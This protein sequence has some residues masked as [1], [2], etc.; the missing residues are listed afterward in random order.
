MLRI[1]E[2]R[3]AAYAH[4]SLFKGRSG[5]SKGKKNGRVWEMPLQGKETTAIENAAI[6]PSSADSSVVDLGQRSV[7][8]IPATSCLAPGALSHGQK[9]GLLG[10][11]RHC[12]PQ[13]TYL[14]LV[15]R[16]T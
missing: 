11:L 15:Q 10:L 16:I 14:S 3:S 6:H 9:A 5:H 1:K 2:V 4:I 7:A 12:A 8:V 13:D